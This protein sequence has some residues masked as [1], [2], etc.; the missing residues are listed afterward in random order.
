MVETEVDKQKRVA[1]A[2]GNVRL[3]KKVI[4]KVSNVK[5]K[6]GA[7]LRKRKSTNEKYFPL[8]ESGKNLPPDENEKYFSSENKESATWGLHNN[9]AA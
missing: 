9:P 7:H 3:V 5:G 4:P 1:Q 8:Q 2:I 6:Q